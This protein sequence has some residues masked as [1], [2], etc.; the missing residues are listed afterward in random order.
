MTDYVEY[1]V[2]YRSSDLPA[3]SEEP[4]VFE[5]RR[6]IDDAANAARFVRELR[7][8]YRRSLHAVANGNASHEQFEKL[9]ATG[10]GFYWNR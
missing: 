4:S 10:A 6:E 7:R 5:L 2:A 3:Y 1:G 8:R 9:R